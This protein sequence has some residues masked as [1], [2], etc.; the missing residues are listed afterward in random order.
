LKNVILV[1]AL[2]LAV[3]LSACGQ[4]ASPADQP[5]AESTTAAMSNMQQPTAAKMAK[6]TG[7]VTAL[8]ASAGT[9]TLNHQAMPEVEWPAMTMTFSAD[10]QVL[11]GVKVGDKVTFDASIEGSTGKVTAITK[12]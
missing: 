7:V 1:T 6:G 5:A 3:S 11:K 9:I 2:A 8:D 10:P 12:S 4:D